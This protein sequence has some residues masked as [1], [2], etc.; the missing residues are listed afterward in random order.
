MKCVPQK[1][2]TGTT[3]KH[4]HFFPHLHTP[5]LSPCCF[6]LRLFLLVFCYLFIIVPGC[7]VVQFFCVGP[8]CPA[9]IKKMIKHQTKY[10]AYTNIIEFEFKKKKGTSARLV[11]PSFFSRRV[12]LRTR[13]WMSLY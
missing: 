4:M 6:E 13:W 10:R 3:Y 2:T 5:S 7:V 1:K 11:A 9:G 8:F 12:K